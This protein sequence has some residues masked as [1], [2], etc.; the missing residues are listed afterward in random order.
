[1]ENEKSDLTFG[2]HPVLEAFEA[3]K[4]IEKLFLQNGMQGPN[5]EKIKK[6]ANEAGTAINQVPVFKLNKLTRK[7]HQGVLAIGS[8][9][10]YQSISEV[11]QS[12]YEKGE[13]PFILM[14]DRITDVRNI[15]AIARSADA[16]GIH[17]IVVPQKG[18][19]LINSEAMKSSAG[20]LNHVPVCR[21]Q[22]LDDTIRELKDLGL[23][24]IACTEKTDDVLS[25][26]KI[27]GPRAVIMGSEEDGI[28][29]KYLKMADHKAKIEMSGNVGS[30]NVSVAAG[31]VLYHLST[32]K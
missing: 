23:T 7:N 19:A 20:A 25:D 16:F 14:L 6:L 1:M 8:P 2:I 30:L 24:I 15:G 32:K 31:V 10:E 5:V 12:T 3:G 9:I 22:Y 4:V 21:E 28:S 17:A 27:T 11:I 13:D 29:P 26:L 18:T